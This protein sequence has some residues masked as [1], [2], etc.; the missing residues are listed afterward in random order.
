[1]AIWRGPI[2]SEQYII[3]GVLRARRAQDQD[4][5]ERVAARVEE[6]NK[7]CLAAVLSILTLAGGKPCRDAW[8][9]LVKQ[10]EDWFAAMRKVMDGRDQVP[11]VPVDNIL[12]F[13]RRPASQAPSSLP[14]G[15]A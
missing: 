5:A 3:A 14:H 10:G 4:A 7:A 12:P 11:A 13:R 15:V 2:G 6:D 1:M 9:D 8:L